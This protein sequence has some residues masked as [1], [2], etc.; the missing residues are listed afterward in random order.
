MAFKMKGFPMHNAS[1]VKQTRKDKKEQYL[2]SMSEED[3]ALLAKQ[4]AEKAEGVSI[5]VGNNKPVYPK[6]HAKYEEW[7]AEHTTEGYELNPK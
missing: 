7:M 2:Q 5:W 6:G 3:K 4:A 1:P